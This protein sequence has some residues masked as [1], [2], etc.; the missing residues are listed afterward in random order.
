MTDSVT[1]QR[2]FDAPQDLTYSMFVTPEHFSVWFG[3]DELPVPLSELSMDVRE[4]GAWSAAM[5]LPDG[6]VKNWVGTFREL[7]PSDRV[8]FDLTDQPESPERA[9]VT[10]VLTPGADGGTTVS[11]TQETPGWPAEAQEGLR[12]GYGA[13]LDTM[14]TILAKEQA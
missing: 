12:A 8:V 5:H 11:L 14:A 9:A 7:S 13:F 4:G 6:S 1:I 10:V 2:T 3:T